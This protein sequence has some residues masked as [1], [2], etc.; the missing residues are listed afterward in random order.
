MADDLKETGRQDDTRININQ[1]H[2]INYWSK[3]LGISPNELRQAVGYA[4]PII[5]DVRRYLNR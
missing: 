1:D 5:K 3:E 2:E 4:G